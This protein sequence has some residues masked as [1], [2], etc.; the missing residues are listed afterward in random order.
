MFEEL[1]NLSTHLA[2]KN[3][4][5]NLVVR[6]NDSTCIPINHL[7][8]THKSPLD[9]LK[10]RIGEEMGHELTYFVDDRIMALS[11]IR[12]AEG[13]FIGKHYDFNWSNGKKYTIIYEVNRSDSN[14]SYVDDDNR[15]TEIIPR[16]NQVIVFPT[17]QY[18][19]YIPK[20]TSGDRTSVC[21]EVF[22]DG[23]FAPWYKRWLKHVYDYLLF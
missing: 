11:V 18:L 10:Q 16:D 23:T 7:T 20:I 14:F 1:I 5:G 8:A 6:K 9:S 3:S 15:K 4:R 19:H 17:G 2:S 22:T 13:D 12:Y 21:L